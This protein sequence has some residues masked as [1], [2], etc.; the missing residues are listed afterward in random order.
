[1]NRRSWILVGAVVIFAGLLFYTL[2]GSGPREETGALAPETFWREDRN[3]VQ[4]LEI[5]R[6]GHPA[7]VLERAD[8]KSVV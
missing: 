3:A 5:E 7:L 1:M 2:R 6:D 4:R 8:R